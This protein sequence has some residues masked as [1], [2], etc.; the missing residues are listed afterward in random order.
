MIKPTW[1]ERAKATHRF[2]ADKVKGS[3]KKWRV[4]DTAKLLRRSVGSISE[5]LLIARWCRTHEKELEQ[6][7]NAYDALAFIRKKILEQ[8]VDHIE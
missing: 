4:K 5:D 8:N 7:E 1:I 6:L 3:E 2:H